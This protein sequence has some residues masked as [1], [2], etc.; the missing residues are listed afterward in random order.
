MNKVRISRYN[1]VDPLSGSITYILYDKITR[2]A[3]LIDANNFELIDRFMSQNKLKLEYII[4]THEE[5]QKK[6]KFQV[7]ASKKCAEELIANPE[8][9]SRNYCIYV[10]FKNKKASLKSI[11]LKKIIVDMQFEN[12]MDFT[13][14]GNRLELF[15]VNGHSK[16]SICIIVNHCLLFTGDNLLKERT[17]ITPFFG[18]NK[19]E[20]MTKTLDFFKSLDG[21][22]TVLPGHGNVFKL[23]EKTLG[24]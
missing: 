22:L 14:R 9:L 15:E 7:I 20:Y 21:N 11:C 1:L 13:W 23:N 24:E 4:L 6:Y 16:G 19:Q 18:S 5:L 3:V 8:R 12:K 17:F 2:Y 10:T